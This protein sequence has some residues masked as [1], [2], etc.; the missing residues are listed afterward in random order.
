[1]P[2]L[3]L[4]LTFWCGPALAQKKSWGISSAWHFGFLVAHNPTMLHLV[5]DHIKGVEVTFFRQTDGSAAWQSDYLFPQTGINLIYLDLP[6]DTVLGEAVAVMGFIDMPVLFSKSYRLSIR[7]SCGLGY[8]SHHFERVENHKN[9]AIGSALNAAVQFNLKNSFRITPRMELNLGVGVTH[10]SNGSLN[11]PN[12]GLNNI[13]AS[14]GLTYMLSSPDTFYQKPK[15][16]PTKKWF[17]ETVL[18]AG[19]KEI[20]PPD[21]GKYFCA[22]L[23]VNR[24]HRISPK[25]ALGF[26]GD[27][28]YDSALN[29]LIENKE[30]HP[31]DVAPFRAGVHFSYELLISRVSALFDYGVYV[32]NPYKGDGPFYHRIGLRYQLKSNLFLNLS[33]KTHFAKAEFAEWGLGWKFQ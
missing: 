23:V 12:L 22:S 32:I 6:S 2:W 10:F 16:I 7:S 17:V 28:F 31:A 33:L 21:D 13:T 19:A 26:G 1:M 29:T 8:L 30:N 5:D 18:A 4:L 3:A 9:A 24:K 25:S 20:Y 27:F 15:S 14:G 11:T